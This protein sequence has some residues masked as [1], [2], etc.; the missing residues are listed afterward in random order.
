MTIPKSNFDPNL[1]EYGFRE[2]WASFATRNS[3]F[4]QRFDNLGKA[5]DVAFTRTHQKLDLTNRTIYFLGRTAAEDFL[6]I[7]LLVGNGY[8]IGAQKLLRGMYERA[9]TARYLRKNPSEARKFLEYHK[10]SDRKFLKAVQSSMKDGIFSKEQADQIEREFEEVKDQFM[11]PDCK[12]CETT[13]LNYTWSKID[14]VSMARMDDDLWPLIV[15]AYYQPTRE[16][17][18]TMGSIFSRLDSDSLDKDNGLLFNSGAQR[19]RADQ[20][21]VTAH[22]ILLSVLD[23]QRECFGIKELEPLMQTCFEDFKAVVDENRK[24]SESENRA[25]ANAEG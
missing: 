6:E 15:P 24:R 22:T 2:E 1:V 8:G 7:V 23:L 21:I 14:F 3:E 10:V 18:S 25:G 20:A 11:V 17:H 5:L 13:R 19:D 16:A 9:I 4:A 12:K